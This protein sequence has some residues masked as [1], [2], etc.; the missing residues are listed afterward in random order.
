MAKPDHARVEFYARQAS[1]YVE[2]AADCLEFE[3]QDEFLWHARRAT[4]AILLAVLAAR[5][6]PDPSAGEATLDKLRSLVKELPQVPFD[7]RADLEAV[8]N[9]ANMGSHALLLSQ[10]AQS[11]G[12]PAGAADK[13]RRHFP[14]VMKWA[15]DQPVLGRMLDGRT[16][17]HIARIAHRTGRSRVRQAFDD[18]DSAV[19]ASRSR[20][21][22]GMTLGGTL[23]AAAGAVLIY[24]LVSKQE[25]RPL[26]T[27]DTAPRQAPAP[28][29]APGPTVVVPPTVPIP[30]PA[31]THVTNVEDA[32]PRNPS[33]N[34]LRGSDC[35]AG[36][37]FLGSAVLD[38]LDPPTPRPYWPP[39]SAATQVT[40]EALCVDNKRVRADEFARCVSDGSC[41]WLGSP[42]SGPEEATHLS[43]RSA[44]DYC[45]WAGDRWHM[46][47]ALLRIA[48]W[49]VLARQGARGVELGRR[50][51]EWV[52]DQAFAALWSM[53]PRDNDRMT[54]Q[55]RVEG[56][57][58]SASLWS[59][60]HANES[61]GAGTIAFRC[62][63]RLAPR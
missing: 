6:E 33:N 46:R 5:G 49:E 32:S 57:R 8:R 38:R 3:R 14:E 2:R 17:E 18:R 15:R 62:G 43:A 56:A 63:Y 23:G 21:A 48:E 22:L 53:S 42:E 47:G 19:S 37:T 44:D 45:R 31:P 12:S 52:Q 11:S 27:P 61:R 39:S 59:W 4:E 50:D 58:G 51:F 30:S 24:A 36:T 16:E 60:N 13:V 54:R 25:A 1:Q 41:T 26:D 55:G 35:P 40:V 28:I 7:V 20:F 34:A 9:N 29:E 10:S